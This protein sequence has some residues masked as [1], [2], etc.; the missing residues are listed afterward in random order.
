MDTQD[1]IKALGTDAK[2]PSR[3]MRQAWVL[4]SA[5]AVLLAAIVFFA[6]LGPRPDIAEA[7]GSLR[8]L[9][10]F[11]V[12]LALALT[13]LAAA[14]RLVRPEIYSAKAV[15]WLLLAPALLAAAIGAELMSLPRDGWN[16]AWIGK[17]AMLCLT[18]IPM[19]GLG[20]LVVFIAALRH[21]APTH[22]VVSGAIAGLLSGG[23][24]A[25]FYAA[26]CTDDSPLFVATWYTLAVTILALLGGLAGRLFVR[27]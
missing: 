8:F 6:T 2:S 18:F 10:K 21:G 17:N 4:A 24:A 1:L 11:V 5:A 26:H 19:I 7:A 9:F 25:T 3:S 20:P 14:A 13:A 27:W 23:L 22:P 15:G 16:S 12:T